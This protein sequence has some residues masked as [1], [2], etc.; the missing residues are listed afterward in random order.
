[1]SNSVGQVLCIWEKG[2]SSVTC[3][4]KL[5][6]FKQAGSP[7]CRVSLGGASAGRGLSVCDG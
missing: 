6:G 4:K 1:M 2:N 5:K 7:P 3:K